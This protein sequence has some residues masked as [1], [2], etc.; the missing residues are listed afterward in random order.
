MKSSGGVWQKVGDL[1][2]LTQI[3]AENAPFKKGRSPTAGANAM[4]GI[5]GLTKNPGLA[6]A[7]A[8]R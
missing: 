3:P 8:L 4:Q 1:G 2:D 6:V 7:V 5:P